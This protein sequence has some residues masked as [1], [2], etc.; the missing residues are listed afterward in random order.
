MIEIDKVVTGTEEDIKQETSY[1]L[2]YNDE[3]SSHIKS[4]LLLKVNKTKSFDGTVYVDDLDVIAKYE[5]F[6][7]NNVQEVDVRIQVFSE[8]VSSD[9]LEIVM[10]G[11]KKVL[12]I[13]GKEILKLSS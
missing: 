3:E 10:E 9:E 1:I 7:S 6:L 12:E 8:D 2:V 4:F 5:A 11:N 13:I